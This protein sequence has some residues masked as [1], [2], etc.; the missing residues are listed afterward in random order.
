MKDQSIKRHVAKTIT[1]RIV[2]TLST[3][4]LTWIISGDPLVGLTVGGWEFFIKMF[5]YY[6]HERV[7]YRVNFGLDRSKRKSDGN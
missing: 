1:W 5:L 7:W 2:A 6:A 4:I 3:V